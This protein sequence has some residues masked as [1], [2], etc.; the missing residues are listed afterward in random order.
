MRRVRACPANLRTSER[1]AR[2]QYSKRAASSMRISEEEGRAMAG[3]TLM[4]PLVSWPTA[5]AA[6]GVFLIWRGVFGRSRGPRRSRD[7]AIPG[8]ATLARGR[9]GEEPRRTRARD[10]LCLARADVREP[11]GSPAG[12]PALGARTA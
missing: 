11:R 9:R 10:R 1:E 2:T 4:A 3:R 5:A 8:V 12:A 6:A 7:R